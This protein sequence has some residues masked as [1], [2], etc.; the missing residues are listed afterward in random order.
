MAAVV[1]GELCEGGGGAAAE[2]VAFEAPAAV[3]G[4]AGEAG[5]GVVAAGAA[6][7]AT[8]PVGGGGREGAVGEGGE[9]ETAALERRV[10]G[11][12]LYGWPDCERAV[13]DDG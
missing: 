11:V 5:A 8:G 4:E 2:A 6:P 13:V 3:A 12:G 7:D 9:G 10:A 1:E